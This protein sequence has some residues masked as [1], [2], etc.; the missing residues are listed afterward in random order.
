[1]TYFSQNDHMAL[2]SSEMNRQGGENGLQRVFM[3]MQDLHRDLQPRLRKLNIDLFT[4]AK[5]M[6]DVT[7]DTSACNTHSEVMTLSYMR[8][9]TQAKVIEGI[10]G[11]DALNNSD[12]IEAQRHPVI[13]L[14]MSPDGFAIEFLIAPDAWYDQQNVVG[15][16]TV[17]EHRLALYNLLNNL[18]GDYRVGFW[19]GA[20]LDDMHL[21]TEQ[22]PPA[23]VMSQWLDTFAAGRDW[24]RVGI[25]YEPEAIELASENIVETVLTHIRELYALYEFVSWNSNNNYHNFYKRAVAQTR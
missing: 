1:M 14:R 9:R 16:L 7:T 20:H 24:F 17:Q 13:E 18:S 5:M 25:W 19:N 11:R 12:T 3:R 8:S 6:E 22:L 2:L 23:H 4:N 15:K 10:M 21:S